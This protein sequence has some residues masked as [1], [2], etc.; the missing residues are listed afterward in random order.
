MFAAA[1]DG[2]SVI[3]AAMSLTIQE[4]PRGGGGKGGVGGGTSNIEGDS[5]GSIGGK[6]DALART[7]FFKVA[8]RSCGWMEAC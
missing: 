2:V 8:R 7:P 3:A 1:D 6:L 4:V 5:T